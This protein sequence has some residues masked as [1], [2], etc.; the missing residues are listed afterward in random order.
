MGVSHND[1]GFIRKNTAS[2]TI[3]KLAP[4]NPVYWKILDIDYRI[5]IISTFTLYDR[6]SPTNR[7]G[8]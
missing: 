6:Y 4:W 2:Y 7:W 8:I 5:T 1:E 3:K